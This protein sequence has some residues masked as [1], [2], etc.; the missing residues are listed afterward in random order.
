[1]SIIRYEQIH[2][3]FTLRDGGIDSKKKEETSAWHV[4]PVATIV[5][6][7]CRALWSPSSYLAVDESI[8]AYRGRTLHKV[9]LPNKTI[10]KGYKVWILGDAGYVYD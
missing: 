1:M 8:I 4:E 9:K 7:N 5:K 2:R 3:Y 6:Q 10:K